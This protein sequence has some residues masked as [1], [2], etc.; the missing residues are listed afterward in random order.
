MDPGARAGQPALPPGPGVDPAAFPLLG[1]ARR[2]RPPGGLPARRGRVH[3]A[4][5]DGQRDAPHLV[6]PQPAP[7]AQRLDQ[8]ARALVVAPAL[9]P[10][11]V[12]LAA[13]V[14][15][16]LD[17]R[18]PS[19]DPIQ[20]HTSS[21]E[22]PRRAVIPGPACLRSFDP[23]KDLLL[24][25]FTPVSMLASSAFLRAPIA[26]GRLL[27]AAAEF[28]DAAP[29]PPPPPPPPPRG[30]LLY[31]RGQVLTKEEGGCKPHCLKY[32][33]GIRQQA[34]P[35]LRRQPQTSTSAAPGPA[36]LPSP[37][38]PAPVGAGARALRRARGGA[39]AR[40]CGPLAALCRRDAQRDLLP[41]DAGQRLGAHRGAADD[42]L[43]PRG[44]SSLRSPPPPPPRSCA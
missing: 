43:H 28:E 23:A 8:H 30:W 24:P 5:R 35:H 31:F 6:G 27:A 2:G 32:S 21:A 18:Q 16:P 38:R 37:P 10:F 15:R 40:I 9:P 42:G 20:G 36:P 11:H 17:P 19:C 22:S 7:P 41:R 1:A 33:F 4:G 14:R 13:L 12:R 25:V 44:A 26:P 29:L 34:T 3:R 39:R